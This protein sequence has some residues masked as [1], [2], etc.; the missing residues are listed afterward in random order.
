MQ[1]GIAVDKNILVLYSNT[2]THGRNDANGAFIPEAKHFAKLHAVPDKQV[3]GINLLINK[4]T[5][6][7]KTYEA[8]EGCYT[9][10]DPIEA[11]AMFGHGW[12]DGIQFGFNRKHIPEF[13]DLLAENC[14]PDLKVILFACLTAEND[15]RDLMH[16]NVGP[17]TDGGFADLLRDQ[18][19]REGFETG[20]VDAHKT[21]GH[22]SWNP[23]LVRFLHSSVTDVDYGAVGG[24]WVVAPGS[25]S[26]RSWINALKSKKNA[27]RWRFP[28]MTELQIKAELAGVVVP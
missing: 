28:F 21:A 17:G 7:R 8:I 13:A 3:I 23:Y 10:G 14:T 16:G 6:R 18:M 1:R 26:W 25:E 4:K 11:V 24:H 27:M 20:W 22:T 5:R 15:E 2:N 9:K 19:V 12:P